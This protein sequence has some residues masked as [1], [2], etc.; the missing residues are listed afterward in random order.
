MSF[1]RVNDFS[2]RDPDR[3]EREL[4]EMEDNINSEFVA[5]R[6]EFAPQMRVETFRSLDVASGIRAVRFD[7]QLSLDTGVASVAVVFPALDPRNFGRRFVLI[8]R[9]GS[10]SIVTSCQDPTVLCNGAAFPTL[11]AVGAYAFYCDASG[12]YR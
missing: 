5:V 9:L 12:Y 10:N 8:K 7:E 2:T 1:D 3:L 6:K 11:A 4:S